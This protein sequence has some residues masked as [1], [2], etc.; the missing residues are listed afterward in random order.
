MTALPEK[1]FASWASVKLVVSPIDISGDKRLDFLFPNRFQRDIAF[2]A[3]GKKAIPIQRQSE[4]LNDRPKLFN[5]ILT[6][7]EQAFWPRMLF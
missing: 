3:P 5:R 6:C 7:E 2:E 1:L 4:R